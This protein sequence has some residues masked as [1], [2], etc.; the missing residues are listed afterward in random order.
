MNS[1]DLVLAPDGIFTGLSDALEGGIVVLRGDRIVHVGSPRPG[2]LRTATRLAGTTLL[3]GLIDAHTHVSI[4]PSR[5]DQLAQMRLP[6]DVQLAT[7]RSHVLQDLLSGVTTMRVMGQEFGVDFTVR[8]EI[9]AGLTLGPD[10]VCAGVQL[11]APGAHGHAST[12]VAS[13]EDIVKVVESNV[14]RG[15]RLAKIFTT[16]GVS[17]VSTSPGDVPFPAAKVRCAADAAHRHGLKLAAHAHGG[18]GAAIAIR[19][20]VDTIEHGVLLDEGMIAEAAERRIAIVGTFSIVDHPAGIEAGDERRSEIVGKLRHVRHRMGETWRRILAT[21]PDIAVGTDSMHGCLAFEVARLVAYGATPA[22]A[23]RAVTRGGADVC[24]LAD[25]GV[26]APGMR[27]DV[28]A[29]LGDPFT[30]IRALGSPVL[31]IKAGRVVHRL[32][33]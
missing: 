10:L 21:V 18:E 4:I 3:P 5:G 11:A 9:E 17:S 22:R 14:A 25:R 15:A 23:L 28:I 8:D 27:A 33:V 20:G 26:L 16:G 13:D 6:L 1:T 31:V 29:V 30:D 12:A 7:A 19:N 32:A 24:G 2:D